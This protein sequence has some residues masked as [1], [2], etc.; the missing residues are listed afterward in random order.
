VTTFISRY[1]TDGPGVALAVKDLID[2]EGEVT[3]AGCKAVADHAAPATHDA[4]CLAGARAAG[5]RI[6]GR[7]NLH[8]L[9]FGVTGINHWY[10]TPVNPLGENLVPGGSSSGCAV[11]VATHQADVAFGSDTGGSVR[12]PAAC[13]GTTGL[14][15]TWGRVPT[16]GVFPLAPSFDTIGPMARDIAGLVLGMQLLEP[17]FEVRTAGQLRVGRLRVPAAAVIDEAIDAALRGTGWE[18][19]DLGLEGWDDATANGGLVLVAEAW[20]SNRALAEA[21]PEGISP[22]V[23]ERLYLGRGVDAEARQHAE[24]AVTDWRRQL[25]DHFERV[26]V[27]ATP[28]LTVLTPEVHEGA[29]LLV[30]R[31]TIPV[32]LA[33]VPALAMPVPTRGALPASLQLIGPHDAEALLLEAGAAVEAALATR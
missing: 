27:I 6:V 26:D 8:E 24:Q 20:D 2:M 16:D 5:A 7:A 25:E 21:H 32:N 31:C 33:G 18:M 1:E 30:G 10:G 11:A 3:T 19:V 17:G 29:E 4:A 28:T 22:D 9:A 15:T 23:M 13:C 12:I 14:K